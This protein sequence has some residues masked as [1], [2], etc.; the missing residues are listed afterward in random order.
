[1]EYIE[2]TNELDYQGLFVVG[3]CAVGAGSVFATISILTFVGMI[4]MGLCFMAIALAN[5]DKWNE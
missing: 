5:K 1:M 3:I 4:G 2:K